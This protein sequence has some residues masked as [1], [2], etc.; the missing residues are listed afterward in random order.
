MCNT[1]P[2]DL[3]ELA[4]EI[5]ITPEMIRAGTMRMR[6]TDT[7]SYDRFEDIVVA[8]FTEMELT[9]RSGRLSPEIEALYENE[10]S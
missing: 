8:V 9:R 7:L 4:G 5:E 3:R 10:P 6:L 1:G 2:A